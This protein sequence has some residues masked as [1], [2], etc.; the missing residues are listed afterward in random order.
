MAS[1][2]SSVPDH[3]SERSVVARID[4]AKDVDGQ[5]SSMQLLAS[6]ETG[7]VSCT[8]LGCLMLLRDQL[9]NMSG[10]KAV[11]IGRQLLASRWDS[12]CCRKTAR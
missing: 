8:P 12:C 6:G 11:V 10:K 2:A 3:L 9:G 1:C 4:P 7:L 5:A